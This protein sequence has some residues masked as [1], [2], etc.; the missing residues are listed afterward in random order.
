MDSQYN[1]VIVVGDYLYGF[2]S[3]ARRG[4][5]FCVNHR[6]GEQK[7]RYQSVLKR[8]QGLGLGNRLILLGEN[9]HFGIIDA[10]PR[11]CIVRSLTEEPILE[12]PCYS[13]PIVFRG[14]LY[15]R[16]EGNLVCYD[17]REPLESK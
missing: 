12:A 8:G 16:N 3:M 15:L 10:N 2:G 1:S 7:W 6:T 5:L 11:R 9:G 4:N 17:L 14:R 13:A